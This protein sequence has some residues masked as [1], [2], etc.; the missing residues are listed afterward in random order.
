LAINSRTRRIVKRVLHRILSAN[1][2]RSVQ[3]RVKARDIRRGTYH[4]KELHL[5]PRAV[6]SGETVIDVGANFGLYSYHLA[7][8]VGDT[9]RVYAFEPIPFTHSCL[10]TIL[11]LWDIENVTVIRKGC[12]NVNET[13]SFTL[14]LQESGAIRAGLS[15]MS[16]NRDRGRG[17]ESREDSQTVSCEVVR[18][19]TQLADV[20]PSF[21]KIDVEGAEI[22]VLEGAARSV[23]RS[24]PTVVCEINPWFLEESGIEL[25][26]LLGFFLDRDYGIYQ[27]T[28]DGRLE[29]HA[30]KPI[31]GGNYVFVHPSRRSRFRE[32]SRAGDPGM[33]PAPTNSDSP[34]RRVP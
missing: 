22:L 15:H 27:C 20:T 29:T 25:G 11:K 14:P 32:L 23:D 3:S 30:A 21:M 24:W 9:G 31:T 10:Q 13:V 5:I 33:E 8:A 7:R 17:S 6:L 26:R 34:P 12:S 1:S 19:D 16:G 18:I 28:E 2:Y 4:E